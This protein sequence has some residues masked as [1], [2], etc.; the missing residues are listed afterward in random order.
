M[1]T[2]QELNAYSLTLLEFNDTRSADVLF[3]RTTPNNQTL[4]LAINQTHLI[5]LGIR[6]IEIID[7]AQTQVNYVINLSSIAGQSS[8]NFGTLPT[9]VN[10]VESP[11]NVFTLTG[12]NSSTV[13]EQIARPIVTL[14][15]NTTGNQNYTVTIKYN[16]ATE[17]NLTKSWTV[18]LNIGE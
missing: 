2:L 13:W 6:I 14:A 15:Q 1:N 10:L 11:Q 12:I 5:P 3:D 8:L 9:G 4:S 17:S 16:T 18:N 7:P